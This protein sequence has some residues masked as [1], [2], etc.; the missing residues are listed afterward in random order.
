YWP[1]EGVFQAAADGNGF[2]YDSINAVAPGVEGSRTSEET[3]N[4]AQR[5]AGGVW[6]S[7]TIAPRH[8]RGT[9]LKIGSALEYRAFSSDL[10]RAALEPPDQTPLSEYTSERTPYVRE[11]L[12]EPA[13]YLP[14]VV[15]CPA[16]GEPCP[17]QIAE[18]A[19]VPPGTEFGG[20]N[21]VGVVGEELNPLT[22]IA[23]VAS[24]PDMSHVLL[25]SPISLTEHGK[26]NLYE[27]SAGRLKPV[28]VLPDG[29]EVSAGVAGEETGRRNVVSNDR[30][31]GFWGGRG[32]DGGGFVLDAENQ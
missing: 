8:S 28:G 29:E 3:Q 2:T 31:R 13:T 22:R 16:A 17:A 12:T 5:S 4:L 19:D 11:N 6:Q 26:P 18:H 10:S 24:T 27:W 1:V 30:I 21:L 32:V 20:G 9:G 7:Q 14:L 23:Y 15:G 25:S